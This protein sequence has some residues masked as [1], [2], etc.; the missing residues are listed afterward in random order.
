M[1]DQYFFETTQ[2][3]RRNHPVRV[4]TRL[5]R[6]QARDE[7]RRQREAET[8]RMA[9]ARIQSMIVELER[10]AANLDHSIE[11]TLDGSRTRDPRN[12]AYPIAARSMRS[13]RDNIKNTIAV[14]SARSAKIA[15]S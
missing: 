5:A 10:E 8:N 7:M 6:F 15:G 4:R 3:E 2:S 14:L 11:A 9:V 12:F 13:R 1:T